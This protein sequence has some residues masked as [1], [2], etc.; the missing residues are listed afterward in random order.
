[1]YAAEYPWAANPT[2]SVFLLR[3]FAEH[4]P[5]AAA[6]A[7]AF[8]D[9]GSYVTGRLAGVGGEPV[10]DHSHASRTGFFNVRTRSFDA[11]TL[12]WAGDWTGKAPRLVPSGRVIGQL[13]APAAERLGLP[14]SV[15]V[16]SGAHDHFAAA[17]ASGVRVAGDAMLS[18]GTSE[19]LFVLANDL[20]HDVPR[21]VDLGA[22]VD[23]RTSYLHRNVRAGQ[24]F[25]RWRDLLR[26]TTPEP[27][28][29]EPATWDARSPL[30]VID[31]ARS[32]ATLANVPFAVEPADLMRVLSEGLAVNARRMLESIESAA[33][34]PVQALTVAGPAGEQ[35][36][37]LR[38]RAAILGRPL[39]VVRTP[40][41][42]ALGAALL[43]Q[44]GMCRHADT[45]V[46]TR[47][48]EPPTEPGPRGYYET[49]L[50]A[51]AKAAGTSAS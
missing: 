21:E 5:D 20:P 43:A 8:T 24:L 1:V 16:V 50:A 37:W 27:T 39:R 40:E 34:R 19:A 4:R 41:P 49:L 2:Y 42:T 17:F 6:G 10:M 18:A 3:W 38:M 26:L 13:A 48:V 7:V 22:F 36:A 29:F 15:A 25:S 32:A 30:M 45:P 23:E 33:G 35:D 11:D 12:A 9:V 47:V 28:W 44:R 31:G 46:A 51:Y 14:G